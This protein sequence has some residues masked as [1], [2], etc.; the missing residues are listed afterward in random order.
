MRKIGISPRFGV[1]QIAM[2]FAVAAWALSAF[3]GD[4]DERRFLYQWIDERGSVHIT[5]SLEKVPGQFR[6]KASRVEQGAAPGVEPQQMEPERPA[7]E[8]GSFGFSQDDL[9]AQNEEDRKLEWQQRMY[10]ARQRMA[11]A[12]ARIRSASE[13]L[14]VLQQKSGYG[15]YGYTPEAQAEV[16]RLEEEIARAQTELDYARDQVENVI[17]EQARKAGVPPGWLREVQ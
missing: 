17:P 7:P 4:Q 14:K 10:D 5:D 6:E 3:G 1:L 8:G 9:S 11:D 2:L 13:K 16:A 15:L 12:E